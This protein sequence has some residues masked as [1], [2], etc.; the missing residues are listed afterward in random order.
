MGADNNN[1]CT[2]WAF[3]RSFFAN[4]HHWR[5]ILKSIRAHSFD[6]A[7]CLASLLPHDQ[8]SARWAGL[9]RI[10]LTRRFFY[11]IEGPIALHWLDSLLYCGALSA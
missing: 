1:A 4:R 6:H 5:N 8:P 2:V 11:I 9:E 3:L 7:Y 10:V